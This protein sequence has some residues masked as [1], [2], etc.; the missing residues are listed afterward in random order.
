MCPAGSSLHTPR[1]GRERPKS[2]HRCYLL[3]GSS[4]HQQGK[5]FQN[6]QTNKQ[7][8]LQICGSQ[9]SGESH[10]PCL[11]PHAPT[12]LYFCPNSNLE[13]GSRCF[14]CTLIP[15][16][17]CESTAWAAQSSNQLMAQQQWPHVIF[18]AC[19]SLVPLMA[20]SASVGMPRGFLLSLGPT[21]G[22]S[23][24]LW[25]YLK[26]LSFTH[27][28]IQWMNYSLQCSKLLPQPQNLTPK[29]LI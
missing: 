28:K 14:T 19:K 24:L 27:K 26:P 13:L 2:N 10:Q 23:M 9:M 11:G 21:L 18:E 4:T 1:A 12:F 15:G 7:K 16:E 17:Q 25:T 5:G 22:T 8:C 3:W 20:P 29:V 6:K